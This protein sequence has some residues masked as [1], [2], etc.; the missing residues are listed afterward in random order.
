MAFEK[1]AGFF[2][3]SCETCDEPKIKNKKML[4][5]HY[6]VGNYEKVKAA[7]SLLEQRDERIAALEKKNKDSRAKSK[8]KKMDD[9]DE[10][11]LD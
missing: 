1:I 2:S 7:V 10:D 8:K 6:Y 4:V 3:N 9:D 5:T 11:D